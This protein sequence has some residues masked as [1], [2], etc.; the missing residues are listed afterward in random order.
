MKRPLIGITIDS[1]T[2][3]SRRYELP[4]D[5]VTSVALAGGLPL[6]IP[7]GV[8][9]TLITQYVDAVDG[10]VFTGGNDLDPSLYGETRHPNAIPIDPARQ[11]FELALMKEVES[12]RIPALG[13][14]LGSQLMNVYR[15]GSLIQ[16][17][18][19]RDGDDKLEHRRLD[20][21]TRRHKVSINPDSNL[22]K[23]VGT[24]EVVANTR[25]K[26][27]IRQPGRGLRVVATAPDGVIEGIEDP[28]LPMF[29]A[30][31]WHPEN[32]FEDPAHLRLFRHLTEKATE[33]RAR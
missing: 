15:G 12:R 27:A 4:M 31:Q 6:L 3:A 13:V 26:Q 9:H 18:P 2:T 28:T 23:I 32:L 20:D 19:D 8:D 29:M 30:V 10:I 24:T 17:L 33:Y 21:P 7:F 25:H 16:F 1:H 11:N 5:Y 22:A 14:C